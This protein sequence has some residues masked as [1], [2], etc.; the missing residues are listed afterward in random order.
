MKPNY[1]LVLSSLSFLGPVVICYQTNNYYLSGIYCMVTLVSSSYH[2]TKNPIILYIDYPLNQLAHIITF[3]RI[4]DGGWAS[5][6]Y[7]SIWLSYVL[8]IYYY[9]YSHKIMTWNPDLEKATPWHMSLHISTAA[10]TC[11]TV[12]KSS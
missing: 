1:W 6:P 12:A 3:H 5:L 8:F 9:G 4:L 7:Y 11:Y 2:A 10:M